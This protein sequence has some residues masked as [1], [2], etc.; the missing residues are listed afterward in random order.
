MAKSAPGRLERLGST[1]TC[2]NHLIFANALGSVR[3][4]AFA[5]RLSIRRNVE[6][7]EEDQ[8][9]AQNAASRNG[10]W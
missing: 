9:R 8:V 3:L 6:R 2:G 5:R 7:Y 4:S 10:S 1:P